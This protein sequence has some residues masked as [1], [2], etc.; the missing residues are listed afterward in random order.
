M[1]VKVIDTWNKFQVAI[2]ARS[3]GFRVGGF[4]FETRAVHQLREL[5]K[6]VEII[7]RDPVLFVC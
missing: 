1:Y 4:F 3:L 2:T 5:G 7:C 6:L